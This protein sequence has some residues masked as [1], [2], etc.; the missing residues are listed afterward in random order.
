MQ[1]IETPRLLLRPYQP[2]DFHFPYR[3]I[4]DPEVMHF[5]RAPIKEEAE[6]RKLTD[7]WLQYAIDN[8]G[9]GVWMLETKTDQTIVGYGVVRHVEYT[10]GREIEI[11]YI[12]AK[13]HWRQGYAS[14]AA[15]AFRDYAHQVM[16]AGELVAYTSELNNGSNRVLEKCGFQREGIEKVYNS[17]CLAWRWKAP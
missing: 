12:I 11:G 14:E 17:D 10:P 13:E 16:G 9:Y 2:E 8:P 5:I 1:I 4:S 3:M 15:A 7:L 6:V